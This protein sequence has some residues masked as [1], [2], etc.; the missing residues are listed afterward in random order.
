M[1]LSYPNKARNLSS[2][3]QLKSVIKETNLLK[4]YHT[5][6]NKPTRTMIC[7]FYN[8]LSILP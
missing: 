8:S 7:L 5:F 6:V 1:F 3:L 4:I 2:T